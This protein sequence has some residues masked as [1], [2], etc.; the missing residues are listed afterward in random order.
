MIEE[1]KTSK[2]NEIKP[3][4]FNVEGMDCAEC[5]LKLEKGVAALPGVAEVR[6]SFT[7][8]KMTVQAASPDQVRGAIEARVAELGYG[9]R[10]EGAWGARTKQKENLWAFLSRR[11][12]DLLTVVA[13]LLI[14]AAFLLEL[15]GLPTTV[16]HALYGLAIV[17]GG[18]Y[19][20]RSGVAAARQ[21]I[22]DMNIL[23]TIAAVGAMIIGEWEEGAL[24]M[25]LFSL[26][27]SL[28]SYTMDR[29]R[30]AIRSLMDLS[31]SE[32][33]L[34][35]DDHQERL[36]VEKLKIG[37]RILIKPGERIPMDGVVVE[38]M[39]AVNQAPITGESLPVEKR[40]GDEVFAGT[41]NGEGALIVRVSRLAGED[42]LSRIIQMVEEAQAQKAPS[43]RFVDVFARYYTP[44]VIALAV[45]MAVLP[46]LLN[47]GDFA[48]WFYR[49]L[50]LLVIACPC[51]LVIST[52]VSIVSAIAS[53]A[54][55]GVLIK[56]GAYL[57]QM[58]AIKAMAFDK[59]G[60]LTA[61][62]P[63]VTDVIPLN[64]W[65]RKDVLSLAAAIES[66][67]EHPLALA[68]VQA[69]E[70]EGVS[71]RPAEDFQALAGQ[72]A[73]ARLNGQTVYIGSHEWFEQ[74]GTHELAVCESLAALE[75]QGKTAMMVGV[76]EEVVGLI[77]VA[78]TMR[79]GGQ[80][81]IAS[82]REAG[83]E[84]TVM[85][86]GDNPRLAAVI[87][88]QVGVDEVRAG[89]LPA[90]K[91]AAL[92]ELLTEHGQVAMVGDGVND[93]PALAR[94][95]IGIAMGTAGSDTALETADIAL[96]ADDLSKLVYAMKLSRQTLGII[97]QNIV[98]ALVV[99]AAFMALA[100]IGVATLWMAVFAD[101]GASLIVIL[102]G[103]RLLR[104]QTLGVL[105]TRRVWE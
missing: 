4:V 64:G 34:L 54:R 105:K 86:T 91:V 62:R 28:E 79:P 58:G 33:T 69:A 67:S 76:E 88:Q 8:G 87:G 94:A 81:A 103:M 31:P 1:G 3:L 9:A 13:G 14:L 11:R 40:A 53:A 97:R 92:E 60:T 71:F 99:K 57:E 2:S 20:A 32:A 74:I 73:R 29:A 16:A 17:V 35:H 101:M 59:T 10:L 102:N 15:S 12:R 18:Y 90:D 85:L 42:T 83:I 47:G 49:A 68:V 45:G 89:L 46:P 65:E 66:R 56:G 61:G 26:G 44:A 39:A 96:M 98:F 51:A 52:P 77:A 38:G 23:M 80:E 70:D 7:T 84:R 104:M 21:G 72:G 75:S 48:A 37:D 22:L 36:P 41:I 63:A 30:H 95:T 5:A 27:H 55:A 50:V 78:D 93:A 100:L 6:L 25:F 19:A 43:Q 82:L 24:V